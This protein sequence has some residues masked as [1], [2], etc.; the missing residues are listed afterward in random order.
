MWGYIGAFAGGI[1]AAESVRFIFKACLDD[2]IAKYR[3]Q[4]E[5]LQKKYNSLMEDYNALEQSWNCKQAMERGKDR[6]RNMRDAERF[7]ENLSQKN[8]QFRSN[9]T[10]I[11]EGMK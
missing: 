4:N 5:E 3:K 10:N 9:I 2:A 11:Q 8:A 6:G 1:V 7:A